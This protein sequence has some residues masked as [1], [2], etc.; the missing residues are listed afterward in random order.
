MA[1]AL[2]EDEAATRTSEMQELKFLFDMADTDG[3]GSIEKDELM[4]MLRRLGIIVSET[5]IEYWLGDNDQDSDGVISFPEFCYA[6]QR[7]VVDAAHYTKQDMLD[8]FKM[9]EHPDY[10]G[11][12]LCSILGWY[13]PRDPAAWRLCA[14]F[15]VQVHKGVLVQALTE[16][17]LGERM[18]KEEAVQLADCLSHGQKDGLIDYRALIENICHIHLAS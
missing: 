6:M 10:R 16:Y 17:G 14:R 11:K 9:F 7:K 4:D 15:G 1:A 3:G 8:A 5:E 2:T 13:R 18:A 12:G